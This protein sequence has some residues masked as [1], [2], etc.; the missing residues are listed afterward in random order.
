MLL[1]A[2]FHEVRRNFGRLELQYRATSEPC[3]C[4]RTSPESESHW[5]T[6]HEI[7]GVTL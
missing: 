3:Q 5:V 6:Y 4:G 7:S 2:T 1:D